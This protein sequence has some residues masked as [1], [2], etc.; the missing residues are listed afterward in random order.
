MCPTNWQR[1]EDCESTGVGTYDPNKTKIELKK[2]SNI[3]CFEWR[4]IR[5]NKEKR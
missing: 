2:L 3:V 1:K 5:M 4:T